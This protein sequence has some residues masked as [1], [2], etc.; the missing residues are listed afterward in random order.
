MFKRDAQLCQKKNEIRN[1]IDDHVLELHLARHSK[2]GSL[3]PSLE[4]FA[5]YLDGVDDWLFLVECDK[6]TLKQME[7]KWTLVQS[8]TEEL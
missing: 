2:H 7:E 6:T 5:S 4:E 8:K 3:L 1:Q